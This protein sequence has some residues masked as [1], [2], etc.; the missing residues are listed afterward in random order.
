MTDRS[1]SRRRALSLIVV[2]GA[3]GALAACARTPSTPAAAAL[4]AAPTVAADAAV[5]ARGSFVGASNHVTTGHA[6]VL[7]SAGKF[8]IELEDD[9]SFDGAPDP[10]VALG[11]NGYDADTILSP[12]RSN[13]GRQAYALKPGIDIGRYNEVW[14][15]CEKFSVP[16]GVAKLA[17]T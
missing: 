11:N 7:Q 9:F 3:A 4:P 12:L 15:W 10:K 8:V 17:L 6:R 5:T 13:S 16:L 14:I 1:L 2:G